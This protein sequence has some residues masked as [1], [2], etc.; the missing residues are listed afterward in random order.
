VSECNE[1]GQ[2]EWSLPTT[3]DPQMVC[4]VCGAV[5]ESE[6]VTVSTKKP[7]GGARVGAGRKSD[8]GAK[9][10]TNSVCLTP[11]LWEK[12]K[13]RATADGVS[14]NQWIEAALRRV[15]DLQ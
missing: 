5:Q 13:A 2:A 7:R 14:R 4:A 8:F 6:G 1:C 12:V 11:G 9:K 15:V 3:S 10:Q